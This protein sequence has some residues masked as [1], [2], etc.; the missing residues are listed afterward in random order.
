MMR[1]RRYRGTPQPS[2]FT[3]C[4][5]GVNKAC[6]SEGAALAFALDQT[7]RTGEPFDVCEYGDVIARTEPGS[8]GVLAK[9]TRG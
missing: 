3:V 1:I 7:A 8:D 5:P 2:G 9:L 6:P 4:G